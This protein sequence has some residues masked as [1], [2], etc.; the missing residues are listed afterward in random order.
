MFLLLLRLFTLLLAALSLG[1]SF[2]HLMEMPVRLRW[3]PELWMQTTN[4]G[5]LYFLFGRI[6]AAV[7]DT[8][9]I[10]ARALRFR[11]REIILSNA[12]DGRARGHSLRAANSRVAGLRR[13]RFRVKRCLRLLEVHLDARSP[14]QS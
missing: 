14:I 3:E 6:G 7:S 12:G 10:G 9:P 2:C 11:R 8:L 13:Y 5:G 1:L 4:F